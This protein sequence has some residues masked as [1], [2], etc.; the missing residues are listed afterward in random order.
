MSD[1]SGLMNIEAWSGSDHKHRVF[2]TGA[3]TCV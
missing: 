2:I 3:A 1:T